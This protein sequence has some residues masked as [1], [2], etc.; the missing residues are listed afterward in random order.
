MSIITNKTNICWSIKKFMFMCMIFFLS[1]RLL[2]ANE[3]DISR[4]ISFELLTGVYSLKG[5]NPNSDRINY[6]GEV[7][8]QKHGSNYMLIWKIGRQQTQVGIG[9]LNDHVLSVAFYDL[10]GNATGAVSYSLIED[11]KLEGLWAI[12][13]S[14]TYGKEYLTFNR[15]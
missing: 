3:A 14:E 2:S 15:S 6:R 7:E 5:S 8:I 12:F 1:S 11:G 4:K 10:S 9:I 13:G